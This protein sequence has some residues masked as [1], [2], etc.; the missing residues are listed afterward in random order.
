[1]NAISAL[2][3][4]DPAGADRAIVEL[5]RLLRQTLD[6]PA[7]VSIADEVAMVADYVE[8]HRL[9]LGERLDFELK[10]GPEAWQARLPAMLIQPLIENAIIHGLS[11][12]PEGGTLSLMVG[13][14]G[15][16]LVIEVI[17]DAPADAR[18]S[19]GGLGLANV[20]QRLAATYGDRAALEFERGRASA[21][22]MVKMP[23]ETA[24]R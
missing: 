16:A 21:R 4:K 2:G 15:S 1:M 13:A 7:E 6:R 19:P 14:E 20:R 9:L 3:Y 22:A 24:K 8:L 12:L 18:S 11:P 17:N 23:F 10:V 5:A